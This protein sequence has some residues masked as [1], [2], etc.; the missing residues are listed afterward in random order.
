MAD[1]QPADSSDERA[2]DE[3]APDLEQ[4]LATLRDRVEQRRAKGEYPPGLEADL[5]GHFLRLT[6]DRPPTPAF[7]LAELDGAL[8]DLDHFEY[9]RDAISTSSRLPGGSTMH[10]AIAKGVGRQIQGVFE[11]TQDQSRRVVRA[12]ALL[13]RTT[14]LLAD[15]YDTR[16]IQQLDDLQLQ[17]AQEQARMQQL[18]VQMGEVVARVPGSGLDAWYDADAFNAH[19]RGFAEDIAGRYRDLAALF[20]GCGPVLDIGFGR[21]EFL[22]LLGELGVDAR[23]IESDARLVEW[24]R[25]AAWPPM[26]VAP[27]STCAT[28]TRGAWVAWS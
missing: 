27:S 25:R 24:A 6:G 9:R 16:V 12:M 18:L 7:V 1:E 10:R 28:S 21:G 23:G 8:D 3:Q 20:T 5:D 15:A 26:R 13:A 11:Q 19:F 17:L 14:N 22:E 4:L 2:S